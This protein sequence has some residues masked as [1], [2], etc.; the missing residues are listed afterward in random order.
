MSLPDRF[1]LQ[2]G[3]AGYKIT[4]EY[5]T[6]VC[7]IYFRCGITYLVASLVDLILVLFE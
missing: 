2:G 5:G 3:G 7:I 4:R 6:H 1:D